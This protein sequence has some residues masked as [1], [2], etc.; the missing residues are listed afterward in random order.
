MPFSSDHDSSHPVAASNPDP[1]ASLA[2]PRVRRRFWLFELLMAPFQDHDERAT[3]R[4]TK[5]TTQVEDANGIRVSKAWN[6]NG[7][8]SQ[9]GHA[10][11]ANGNGTRPNGNGTVVNG[12]AAPTSG[13]A[14]G[15]SA[16][17]VNGF[18][19]TGA[20]SH[21]SGNGNR[22]GRFSSAGHPSAGR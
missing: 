6:G 15:G 3:Y 8:P 16:N 20:A 7:V 17:Q 21:Y 13:T 19:V 22:G 9:N 4:E 14:R 5:K 12:A 10:K 1:F 18:A 2:G 11:T